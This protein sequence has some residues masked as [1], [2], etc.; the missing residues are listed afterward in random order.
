MAGSLGR[1]FVK[2]RVENRPKVDEPP[3]ENQPEHGGETKLNDC[4]Q[5]PAL[6]ELT[7]ARNEETA[8]CSDDVAGS[9]LTCHWEI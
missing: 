6:Q 4:E 2:R 5:E 3:E 9:T 1:P 7:E 8:K